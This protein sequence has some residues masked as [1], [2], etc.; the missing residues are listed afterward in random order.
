MNR[1][2]SVAAL[3]CLT[4]TIACSGDSGTPDILNDVV[5]DIPADATLDAVDDVVADTFDPFQMDDVIRLNQ[6]QML[7]THNSYHITS[8]ED[9]TPSE[10]NYTH[11]P[12]LEQLENYGVRQLELDIW[13]TG[14]NLFRCIHLLFIDEKSHCD[15]IRDCLTVAKTWSDANPTHAPIVLIIEIKQAFEVDYD[16]VQGIMDSGFY[17]RLHQMF[18]EVLGADRI[19]TPDSV[20]GS[21]ATLR[22]ALATD[23]WPTLGDVRGK[24]MLILNTTSERAGLRDA[25]LQQFPGLKDAL[26]FAKEVDDTYGSVVELNRATRD[27]DAIATAL[28]NNYMVR[29][30]ADAI[31]WDDATIAELAPVT[32]S[33]GVHWINTDFLTTQP[34]RTYSIDWPA[35]HPVLCNPVNAPEGCLDWMLE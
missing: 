20:R 3:V 13:E 33:Y 11:P 2:M 25:Y 12:I 19:I 24:F 30:A 29:G 6:I 34:G 35:D 14:Q 8:V 7:G 26:M 23:G 5:A 10:I 4:M 27:A 15:N 22:E 28:A 31:G 32:A 21:H 17:T 18:T 16:D 1:L 9:D